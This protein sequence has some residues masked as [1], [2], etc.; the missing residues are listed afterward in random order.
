MMQR[1]KRIQDFDGFN[2]KY[3]DDLKLLLASEENFRDENLQCL[4][5]MLA[6]LF[7]EQN[8]DVCEA[9]MKF[10]FFA[11][12]DLMALIS[13]ILVRSELT[14]S[15]EEFIRH[16][17]QVLVALSLDTTLRSSKV[18]AFL[19]LILHLV[20]RTNN[21]ER[22]KTLSEISTRLD[23][24]EKR[25]NLEVDE[26]GEIV[27]S[28]S[29][30][31][32]LSTM[33]QF[34][35]LPTSA[36]IRDK[37]T[38]K[39]LQRELKRASKSQAH[40]LIEQF[41][42]F[43]QDF[44]GP[45]R[46]GIEDY[47]EHALNPDTEKRFRHE[48]VRLYEGI[49]I[50]ERKCVPDSGMVIE[51]QF[52][53][54]GFKRIQ[55]DFCNFLQYG[56][57]VCLTHGNCDT[58]LYAL[59]AERNTQNLKRGKISL[60]LIG[61]IFQEV[62]E[63]K[64]VANGRIVMLE[65]KAFYTAYRHTL[66][67]M[68][69]MARNMVLYPKDARIPFA[70]HIIDL[71]TDVL[72]P[73]YSRSEDGEV[74]LVNFEC[75]LKP[76][77]CIM[78]KDY[79]RVPL[80]D[81]SMWPSAEEVGMDEHQYS[82]L[83]LCLTKKLGI[84]QGPPGTGKTWM[85]LRI[86]EFL[87]N[88]N[89]GQEVGEKRPI[90]LLSYTNHALDQF[91]NALFDMDSLR[92]LFSGTTQPFV[93]VGSRSNVERIQNCTLT[94]HRKQMKGNRSRFQWKNGMRLKQEIFEIELWLEKIKDSIVSPVF[95]FRNEY[96]SENHS[97]SLQDKR[98]LCNGTDIVAII[99]QWLEIGPR[100][101]EI[102]DFSNEANT[103]DI[104][105]NELWEMDE[106]DEDLF[107]SHLVR[108]IVEDAD[109]LRFDQKECLQNV[110]SNLLVTKELLIPKKKST[111]LHP[112]WQSLELR[113]REQILSYISLRLRLDVAMNLYEAQEVANVWCIT[114]EDRW[115]LYKFWV[116]QFKDY[117]LNKR[118]VLMLDFEMEN[119]KYLKEKTA[120]N[121]KIV[122]SCH[123]VGMTT[124]GAAQN[125][126]LLK[127]VQP[128]IMIVEEAAQ[129]FEQ[130]ILGCLTKDLQ[131]LILIGDH[132]QLRPSIN[133]YQ[134][135]K[136]HKT[137]VS[138]MERLV[139]NKMPYVCLSQQ[140]RMRPEISSMLTP[141]IYK[142]LQ[143]H[144]SVL[145]YDHVQGMKHDIFFLNHKNQESQSE[146][147]TSHK[148]EF[149]AEMVARLCRYLLLQGYNKTDVTI[150]ATY[151]DQVKL[152]RN[153]VKNLENDLPN[154]RLDIKEKIA[155]TAV[156]NFQ[157]EEN[158]IIILS[159]VRGND[160]RKIGHLHDI[161][162]IC[163]SLSRA[164]QGFFVIGN[165]Q[166][167]R[168]SRTWSEIIL[169]AEADNIFGSYIPLNCFNHPQTIT[170]VSKPSD[171]DMVP[172][173]GCNEP[174]GYQLN[175][176]HACDL[177]CHA[178]PSYHDMPCRKICEKEMCDKG[179]RCKRVC[180]H[181]WSCGPCGTLVTKVYTECNHKVQ[182]KCSIDLETYPCR[183]KCSKTNPCGHICQLNC[184]CK[185][186]PD[187]C[188][189]LVPV[190][191][192]RCGHEIEAPCCIRSKPK[193][194]KCKQKCQTILPCGHACKGDCFSCS[195]G[196]LHV[197]C[198]QLCQ[199][200]LVCG[201][202]CN[203]KHSCSTA[204]PPCNKPCMSGCNHLGKRG[205]R[206]KCGETCIDCR[207]QCDWKC[208]ENCENQ[209]RC[210]KQCF[211]KCDRPRCNRRCNRDLRCKHRCVGLCGE[212]CPRLCRRCNKEEL[213]TIFFGEEDDPKALFIELEDCKHVF[214]VNGFDK[215]ME[216]EVE[217]NDES[218]SESHAIK[219]LRCPLCQTP[220]RRSKRYKNIIIQNLK[221]MNA[222]KTIEKEKV[223]TLNAKETFEELSK[224]NE[225]YE[226]LRFKLNLTK[227]YYDFEFSNKQAEK[228]FTFLVPK[229]KERFDKMM[230]KSSEETT[231]I[232]DQFQMLTEWL[233]R[234]RRTM[235]T[236][237]EVKQFSEEVDRFFLYVDYALLVQQVDS[238]NPSQ[239]T[240][241]DRNTLNEQV[242]NLRWPI[243]KQ[244]EIEDILHSKEILTT[245]QE[246]LPLT[247]LGISDK[248]KAM[249]L[250]AF[251]FSKKGHWYKCKNGHIYA[252]G[253]CGGAMV[254]SK[255]PEC[256]ETI[257][258]SRHQLRGDNEV[259]GEMDGAAFSAWSEQ[260]NMANYE[261]DDRF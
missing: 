151:N 192:P 1:F 104:P 135:S 118:N 177:K 244:L 175:C 8:S 128:K 38:P 49:H 248:E 182:V 254:E 223:C 183:E 138:L 260:A 242:V 61:Q 186:Q 225:A 249:I 208:D 166:T 15:D 218:V 97:R 101:R 155:V 257:G 161:K 31:K 122:S 234:H 19:N 52:E 69:S 81:T 217:R 201:H 158:K 227:Q 35:I 11:R 181:P 246:K 100:G 114:I 14:N 202:S 148:N 86:A 113:E 125:I 80:L 70:K 32:E 129:V 136:T 7:E 79:T 28:D 53:A 187:Q 9:L 62:E 13:G 41:Y 90:L 232:V 195:S 95:L 115:R 98:Y 142:N 149:E 60:S 203:N 207:E 20:R 67:S 105:K 37:V 239:V 245:M 64:N 164:K 173:G 157:G 42:L 4:M 236:E 171:F 75:L 172:V 190:V 209:Y 33:S 39:L 71:K 93:R 188:S 106:N 27:F 72:E 111:Q 250:K 167:I 213:T 124:T 17:Y 83:K 252:I 76:E 210:Q 54:K 226:I 65:S 134:L 174:C 230:G 22:E 153:Y 196:R 216:M 247:G 243:P 160:E 261:I 55:W 212:P 45:L 228:L 259:A 51:I 99:F 168:K 147:S 193:K 3:L 47:M 108:R 117:L 197:V 34:Q 102:R 130:H 109:D 44:I 150:L 82:A 231:E 253:D 48:S 221:D 63:M 178:D 159:L 224:F 131:H 184:G 59:I 205:C 140:H 165:F 107:M 235:F 198:E 141:T 229:Y 10:D 238:N 191:H 78:D 256:D 116:Q 66:E 241:E 146:Y 77:E 211:E 12:K 126:D 121:I 57:V 89:L 144:S 199:R 50:L 176:G 68:Q 169:K 219:L 46:Q 91:F 200:V 189:V 110:L 21:Q 26:K 30:K 119:S 170:K 103:A 96:I 123:L 85:G 16:S 112:F 43:L 133:N 5:K 6:H 185:C 163:V 237:Y 29:M 87:L 58:L 206:R 204:C 220:I 94:E 132:Q 251:N 137:D 92:K 215:F 24:K 127:K 88:N 84:L 40:Y 154:S 18:K 255:C 143:D 56:N 120:E 73:L 258:G 222:V 240:E 23:M 233:L 25:E 36:M 194:I 74:K 145:S 214:E 180:S 162:R 2:L 152:I 139:M 179:H 156:D